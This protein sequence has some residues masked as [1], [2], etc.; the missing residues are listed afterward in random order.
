M[1]VFFT[2]DTH[3]GHANV[4][5]YCGRPFRSVAEMDDAL[6]DNWNAA[7]RPT[8][9]VYHLGDFAYRS[10]RPPGRYLDRLNG[11]IHLVRGNH[12]AETLRDCGDRFASVSDLLEVTVEGRTVVLCHYA[13]RTWNGSHRGGGRASWH[14]YGHSHGDLPD[15][16][17][18]FAFDVGVDCHA[19]APVP[20]A[21][22][23]ALMAAKP[24]AAATRPHGDR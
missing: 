5:R 12:D 22:A 19:Y 17:A 6:I 20:F 24:A 18:A 23:A 2:A 16:P 13:M 8:D 21:R 11:T 15:D 1:A 10:R 7:V 4:I 14:L 9:T 3:F